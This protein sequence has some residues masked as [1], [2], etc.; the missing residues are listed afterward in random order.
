MAANQII[1]EP[2]GLSAAGAEGGP[3]RRRVWVPTP[4]LLCD[5]SCCWYARRALTCQVQSVAL[6]GHRAFI[7]MPE[8]RGTQPASSGSLWTPVYDEGETDFR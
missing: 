5:S 8:A 4:P 1:P 6:S 7:L 2:G 3:L